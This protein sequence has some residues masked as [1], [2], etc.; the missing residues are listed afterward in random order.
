[1]SK[2]ILSETIIENSF[3]YIIS[4]K[5]AVNQNH[6]IELT[7]KELDNNK[8]N[9]IILHPLV[10]DRIFDALSY[11]LKEV[12]YIRNIKYHKL[13]ERK[14]KEICSRYLK[15]VDIPDLILQFQ[16]DENI[17]I[18]TLIKKNIEIVNQS[19]PHSVCKTKKKRL[20][21]RNNG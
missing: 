1:M 12:K 17:I 21:K 11:Y 8:I 19:T 4:I 10:E 16:L 9:K 20:R 18:E 15:G 14:K 7:V 5:E 6:F 13:T 3:E 2:I